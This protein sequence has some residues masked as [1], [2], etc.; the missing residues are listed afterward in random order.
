MPLSLPSMSPFMQTAGVHGYAGSRRHGA[1]LADYA[2]Y[3]IE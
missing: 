3:N 2:V 1:A